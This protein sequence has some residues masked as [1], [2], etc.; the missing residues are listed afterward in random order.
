MSISRKAG[1]GATI[2]VVVI[3]GL[4]VVS[5]AAHS[6]LA[7]LVPPNAVRD[8]RCFLGVPERGDQACVSDELSEH[9]SELE[10]LRRARIELTEKNRKL[11]ELEGK[12]DQ[13]NTFAERAHDGLEISTG[14]RW[15]NLAG[16]IG[17]ESAWC[18]T[19]VRVDGLSVKISLASAKPNVGVVP[20]P[21]SDEEKG[22]LGD[23]VT[24][25]LDKCVFP[26]EAL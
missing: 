15:V 23:R 24:G 19:H 1:N 7:G 9:R 2:A 26:S 21:L 4:G 5:M 20:A 25:I 8:A 6:V 17:W 10:T 18:Y 12:F 13:V 11:G 22:V 14:V 3:G 16:D